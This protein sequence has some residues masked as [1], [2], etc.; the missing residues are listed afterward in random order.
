MSWGPKGPQ[1]LS[2]APWFQ[3]VSISTMPSKAVRWHHSWSRWRKPEIQNARRFR[4]SAVFNGGFVSQRLE[5][6]FLCAVQSGEAENTKDGENQRVTWV[7]QVRKSH[8][9]T[10]K[11]RFSFIPISAKSSKIYARWEYGLLV[12]HL[13]VFFTRSFRFFM[14]VCLCLLLVRLFWHSWSPQTKSGKTWNQKKPGAPKVSPSPCCVAGVC[15]GG[16]LGQA[17]TSLAELS[18][19]LQRDVYLPGCS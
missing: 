7:G 18:Q 19:A 6:W 10:I 12:Y 17:R 15:G 9:P 2:V 16:F 13:H 14:F 8:D 1:K 4:V 11:T 5:S 3:L